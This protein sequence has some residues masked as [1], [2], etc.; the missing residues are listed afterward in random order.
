MGDNLVIKDAKAK[1][2][3][4]ETFEMEDTTKGFTFKVN[5]EVS[6]RLREILLDGGL[7]NHTKN[8]A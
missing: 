3:G 1:V 6:E 2:G 4:M 5:L 7:L 8:K